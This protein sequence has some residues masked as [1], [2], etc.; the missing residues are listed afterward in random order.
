MQKTQPIGIEAC[1]REVV[2]CGDNGETML[3]P[4][5]VNKFKCLLLMSDI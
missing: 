5:L 1:K 2:H 4:E 3:S